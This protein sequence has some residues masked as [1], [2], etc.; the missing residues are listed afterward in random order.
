[1]NW[2]AGLSNMG[3]RASSLSARFLLSIFMAKYLSLADIGLFG[4]MVAITS[5]MPALLGFGINHFANREL[6]TLD[7]NETRRRIRD[8]LILSGMVGAIAVGGVCVLY[9]AFSDGPLPNVW[10][11]AVVA[12]Q[13]QVLLDA[14]FALVSVR[15]SVLA[16]ILLFLRSAAWVYPFMVAAWVDAE[17]RNLE[18]L[19]LFWLGGQIC[20][21]AVLLRT[22]ASCPRTPIWED[23]VQLDWHLK[24]VRR[25]KWIYL[26]DICIVVTLFADR[27][28]MGSLLDLEDLGVFVF[29]TTMAGAVHLLVGAAVTQVVQ[30]EFVEL[31]VQRDFTALRQVLSRRI[32]HGL[33]LAV[34]LSA[35]L[36][37]VTDW[38]LL[39]VGREELLYNNLLFGLLL[40]AVVARVFAEILQQAIYA[41]KYDGVFAVVNIVSAVVVVGT[42]AELIAKFG[43]VG[44][45]IAMLLA[46]IGLAIWRMAIIFSKLTEVRNC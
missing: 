30:P 20:T 41:M 9:R 43:L 38:V 32:C 39:T 35:A 23:P 2:I 14:H 15:R 34:L 16:N 45:G 8:R 37:L 28:I 18:S 42:C 17:F 40:S 27:F 3:L 31:A 11:L 6:V 5:S 29:F 21:V 25:S 4:L 7:E 13:E 33:G 36:Y 1:M 46:W 12:T 22:L 19:L 10:L 24:F 26:S 44:G